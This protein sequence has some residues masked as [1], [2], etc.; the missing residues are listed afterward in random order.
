[1][2]AARESGLRI[3]DIPV[4]LSAPGKDLGIRGVAQCTRQ[5]AQDVVVIGIFEGAGDL[6]VLVESIRHMILK[7]NEAVHEVGV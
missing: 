2:A 1:M 7:R 4:V 6:F 5:L 3:D